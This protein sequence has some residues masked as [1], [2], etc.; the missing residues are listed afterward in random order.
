MSDLKKLQKQKNLTLLIFWHTIFVIP[1]GAPPP[2][3]PF[4]SKNILTRFSRKEAKTTEESL[5]LDLPLVIGWGHLP[6]KVMSDL[7]KIAK[8]K[9]I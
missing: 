9:K 1:S 2:N 8:A 4:I 3:G 6:K 5:K 7:K